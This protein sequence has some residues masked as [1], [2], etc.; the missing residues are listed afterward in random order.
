L[1]STDGTFL[2]TLDLS[3]GA[4]TQLGQLGT[5]IL[6]IAWQNGTLYGLGSD[7]YLYTIDPTTANTTYVGDTGILSKQNLLSAGLTA[8]NGHLYTQGINYVTPSSSTLFSINPSNAAANQIGLIGL[9]PYVFTLAASSQ[10]AFYGSEAGNVPSAFYSLGS[11]GAE[12]LLGQTNGYL[13]LAFDPFDNLFG[14]IPDPVGNTATVF[15]VDPATGIGTALV[16]AQIYAIG[17]AFVK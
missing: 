5:Q 10:G 2:Y 4:A 13:G 6:S 3:S 14:V 15:L 1:F 17:I 16:D 7:G 9:S 12:T 11:N 8:Y